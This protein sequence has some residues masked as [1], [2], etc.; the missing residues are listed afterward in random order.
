M[1]QRL[2]TVLERDEE[3]QEILEQDLEALEIVN[4]FDENVDKALNTYLVIYNYKPILH[5]DLKI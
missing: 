4:E 2:E 5:Y 3:D 1:S